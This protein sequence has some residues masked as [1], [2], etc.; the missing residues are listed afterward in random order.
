MN[1]DQRTM[2][3]LRLRAVVTHVNTLLHAGRDRYRARPAPI[4][5][6]AIH[7]STGEHFAWRFPDGRDSPV[8]NFSCQ[9]NMM[10]ILAGLSNLTADPRYRAIAASNYQYHFSHHQ[11][12]NGLLAWGGHQFIDLR[13]LRAVGPAEKNN[14]HELKNAFPFYQMMFQTNPAAARQFVRGLWNAHVSG[15]AMEISRHGKF[16]K[17]LDPRTLWNVREYVKPEPYGEMKGLSFLSAGND[18]I[19][20]GALHAQHTGNEAA[21]TATIL[22]AQQFIGARHARTRLGAYQFSQPLKTAEAASDDH[23]LSCF[24]DRAQRQLGPE[25]EPDPQAPPAKRRVLEATM[26]LE[27]HAKTIYSQNALMQLDIAPRLGPEGGR[28]AAATVEGLLAFAR[29]AYRPGDNMFRPMLTDGTDLSG[30]ALRRNGYYG[31]AGTVLEPYRATCLYLLSYTRAYRS[32][33][34]PALWQTIQALAWNNDLGDW[35]EEAGGT[36]RLNLGTGQ[37]DPF[38]LFAVID[39]YWKT[40]RADYL[41]LARAIGNNLYRT[42]FAHAGAGRLLACFVPDMQHAYA[43]VDAIEPYALL[44]LQAAIDGKPDAVP[45]FIHGAGYTEGEYRLGNG[46]SATL[47]DRSIH[48][49]H[50]GQTLAG[51]GQAA[52]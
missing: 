3:A 15:A 33:A 10:R 29:H 32:S 51:P 31:A 50:R 35:G 14:V 46:Q 43:R 47:Q 34:D 9:Q 23:T 25:L 48:A 18:L 2:D 5:A 13:T 27:R 7:V 17:A 8:C 36:S 40:Q 16:T 12:S 28:L 21:R 30:F 19:Y 52:P 42:R 11:A 39:V 41:A 44:A 38:A 24:G 45:P 37:S 20:A 4:L 1:P 49:L 22:L 26:L 6:D